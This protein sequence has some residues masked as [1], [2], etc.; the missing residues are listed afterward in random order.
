MVIAGAS[1]EP[2]TDMAVQFGQR[3]AAIG[4]SLDVEWGR[5]PTEERTERSE[6]TTCSA[7]R[8][9]YRMTLFS[10]GYRLGPSLA[11]GHLHSA[12]RF[13]ASWIFHRGHCVKV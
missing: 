10:A 13:S 12:S 6:V 8:H 9:P 2:G 7:P 5:G 1:A 4:D 3:I 11:L